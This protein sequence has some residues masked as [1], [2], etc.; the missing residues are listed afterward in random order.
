MFPIRI[1]DLRA[2]AIGGAGGIV[3]AVGL[4]AGLDGLLAR[5]AV[6]AAKRETRVLRAR[7]EALRADAFDLA[8]RLAEGL[9]RGRRIVKLTGV[10]GHAREIQGLSPPS[11]SSANEILLGWLAEQRVVLVAIGNEWAADPVVIGGEQASVAIPQSRGAPPVQDVA[12]V[13]RMA[14]SGS[15][16]RSET[17]PPRR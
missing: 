10:P 14:R 2:L 6:D 9:E 7:Q 12:A 8:D 17:V 5:R 1:S 11:R 4:L 15:A 16:R 13:I 3:V